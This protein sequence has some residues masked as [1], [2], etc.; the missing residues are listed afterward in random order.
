MSA[1]TSQ[2][3]SASPVK[4]R[5]YAIEMVNCNEADINIHQN[6]KFQE[7]DLEIELSDDP[8]IT[9]EVSHHQYMQGL[10]ISI[11]NSLNDEIRNVYCE[12]IKSK[13]YLAMIISQSSPM[14]AGIALG[15]PACQQIQ[16][17]GQTLLIQQCK[18]SNVTIQVERTKCGYE[19]KWDD[20]T[21]G[22]DGFTKRTFHPCTWVNGLVNLNGHAHEYVND[23]WTLVPS[24]VKI[25]S[26]GLKAHFDET[27]DNEAQYLHNLETT[28]H[29]SET[30]QLN[31]IG[32]LMALMRHEDMNFISPIIFNEQARGTLQCLS[33]WWSTLLYSLLE[34]C[35]LIIILICVFRISLSCKCKNQYS[36]I[37]ISTPPPPSRPNTLNIRSALPGPVAP[38]NSPL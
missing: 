2:I 3:H 36:N 7:K 1:I 15:L 4:A 18:L 31:V 11:S 34:I 21:I 6:W 10:L 16:A 17:D 12:S 25:S 29:A 8:G 32:N 22:K 37:P 24:S 30:D 14:L 28:F 9:D 33:D 19:P 23:T 27:I 38:L 26:I 5:P 20:F 35:S 13:Q